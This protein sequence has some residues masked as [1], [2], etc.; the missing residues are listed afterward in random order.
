M[1][2]YIGWPMGGGADHT[3]HSSFRICSQ[4]FK[5][6]K[7]GNVSIFSSGTCV[8]KNICAKL[9]STSRRGGGGGRSQYFGLEVAAI[10]LLP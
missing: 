8:E 6:R 1:A 4:N 10:V 7:N 5:F 9:K 2:A 3:F